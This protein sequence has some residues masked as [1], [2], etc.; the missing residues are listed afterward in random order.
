MGWS[1]LE[2]HKMRKL[3]RDDISRRDFLEILRKVTRTVRKDKAKKGDEKKNAAQGGA[4]RVRN[5]G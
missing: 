5:S 2:V 1:L 4:F 3:K